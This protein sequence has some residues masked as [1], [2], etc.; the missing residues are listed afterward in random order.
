MAELRGTILRS[1]ERGKL[2]RVLNPLA[3]SRLAPL[4]SIP[5]RTHVLLSCVYERQTIEIPWNLA[6]HVV[7]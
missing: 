7:V 2:L 5:G 3:Q 6:A 1:A 4:L